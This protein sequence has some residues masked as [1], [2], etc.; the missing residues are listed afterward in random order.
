MKLTD[1]YKH[2]AELER[3]HKLFDIK[4]K[5]HSVWGAFRVYFNY[6]DLEYKK[7]FAF[8]VNRITFSF[9]NLKN[10]FLT[11][12]KFNIFKIFSRKKYIILQHPRSIDGKDVY[13]EDI[14]DN[15]KNDSLI[16]S[17]S[18]QFTNLRKKVVYLDVVK[19]FS[20]IISKIFYVF[21]KNRKF[22][23]LKL[24][25][26]EFESNAVFFKTFKKFYIEFIIMYYFYKLLL[27]FHKPHC[28]FIVVF[29]ENSALVAAAND[30]NIPVYEI[31]HGIIHKHHLGYN[32]F[33]GTKQSISIFPNAIL[34]L[35]EYWNTQINMPLKKTVIGNNFLYPQKYQKL[36]QKNT[37]L[38]ISQ[39]VIGD[40]MI[41]YL[42]DN[43][44]LL[45]EFEIFFK[46]HPNEFEM[47]ERLKKLQFLS[48]KY[49]NL[50]IVKQ[51]KTI[52][53]LQNL[54]EFQVGVFSTAIYEGLQ[55]G[56]KTIVL[57]LLGIEALQNLID[58]SF[59]KVLKKE[60]KLIQILNEEFD[61]IEIEFFSAFKIKT[62]K[63]Y[64][65]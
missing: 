59:V 13:T 65:K 49:D 35:G 57:D 5:R 15:I 9:K 58:L 54:A 28:I 29:Y 40:F 42:S 45:S 23:N 61:N 39:G 48:K 53:Y 14:I 44:E 33:Y 18:K 12:L 41:D 22:G 3:K 46:L 34:T 55:I 43:I 47:Q 36:K 4:Y 17:F 38:F 21:L 7:I 31:Q 51:N 32:F 37:I 26:I 27:K 30:L 10:L 6:Y 52:N 60:E 8:P 19:V 11:I 50:H 63:N 1:R 56:C 16:L 2:F 24:F 64:Y 62:I 25:L 20:K